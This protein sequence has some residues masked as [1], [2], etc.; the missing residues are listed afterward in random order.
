M[1][2]EKPVL[3]AHASGPMDMV[4]WQGPVGSLWELRVDPGQQ[5]ENRTS[6]LQQDMNSVSSLRNLEADPSPVEP[7]MRDHSPCQLQDCSLIKP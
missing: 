5:E 2:L 7:M 1:K 6:A 3:L 4:L